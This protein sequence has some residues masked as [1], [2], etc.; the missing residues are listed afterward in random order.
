[1]FL[2]TAI[3]SRNGEFNSESQG[4]SISEAMSCGLPV[5]CFDCGGVK[6]TFEDEKSGFLIP[7]KNL[8]QMVE[9]ISYLH[10]NRE[11]LNDMGKEA[12]IFTDTNYS[13]NLIKAKW[14]S[15]YAEMI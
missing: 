10:D 5:V 3:D 13:D 4:L 8:E 12:R 11:I 14:K 1:M 2:F 9:K 15:L 6:Y 7:Q